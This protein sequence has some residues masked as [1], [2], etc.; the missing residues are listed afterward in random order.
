MFRTQIKIGAGFNWVSG[1]E[2]GVQIQASKNCF[3]KKKRMKKFRVLRLDFLCMSLRKH[4]V[5]YGFDFKKFL[6]TFLG[7]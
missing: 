1:H 2:F 7:F 5:Y 3:P 4:T 6:G